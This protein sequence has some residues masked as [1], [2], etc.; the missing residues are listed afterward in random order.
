MNRLDIECSRLR[1]SSVVI[2]PFGAPI[3]EIADQPEQ[4]EG[5]KYDDANDE[6][7]IQGIGK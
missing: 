1:G 4:R 5:D 2:V 6:R 3:D 7:Q